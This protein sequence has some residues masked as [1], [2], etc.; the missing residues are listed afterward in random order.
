MWIWTADDATEDE[1]ERAYL[2]AKENSLMD[3]NHRF[4][5]KYELAEY[6]ISRAKEDGLEL[7]ITTNLFAYDCPSPVMPDTKADGSMH[8]C[9]EDDI[10]LLVDFFE[11]FHDAVEI[12]RESTEQY[13]RNAEDGVKAGSIYLW[14]NPEGEF[15]ASCAWHPAQEMGSIGLVYTRKEYRRKHY[16][17]NLVYQV[18]KIVQ[19]AGYLP[20]LYTDADYVASNKCYEKIGYILRGKLCTIG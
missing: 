7:K 11:M 6:F 14:K 2:T 12:D 10:D 20:M 1:M 17:E 16:A 3:G 5:L 8:Q 4:N 18:T 9:T 19:E 13:R 15:V